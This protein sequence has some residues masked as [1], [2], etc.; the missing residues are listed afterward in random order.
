MQVA[1]KKLAG[2]INFFE[3]GGMNAN[4]LVLGFRAAAEGSL[5]KTIQGKSI[6]YSITPPFH[7]SNCLKLSTC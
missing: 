7:V 5:H 2:E 6:F 4:V 3:I 1:E